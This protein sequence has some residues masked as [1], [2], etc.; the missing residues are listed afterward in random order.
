MVGRDADGKVSYRTTPGLPGAGMRAVMGGLFGTNL[1][2][3]LI[4]AATGAAFGALAGLASKADIDEAFKQQINDQLWPDTSMLFLRAQDTARGTRF[5][6]VCAPSSSRTGWFAP[7]SVRRP[8]GQ[9]RRHCARTSH[10]PSGEP[11]WDWW[12]SPSRPPRA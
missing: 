2:V 3:A 6:S 11:R 10:S 1:C 7:I 8:S 4:G 5:C 12:L 9:Y